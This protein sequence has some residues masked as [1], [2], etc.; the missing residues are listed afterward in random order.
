VWGETLGVEPELLN[1]DRIG[2]ALDAIA[3]HLDWIAGS[4][5]I[6]AIGEF[7]IEVTRMHWDRTSISMHGLYPDNQDGFPAVRFGHPK[8]RRPDL[9]TSRRGSR[10]APMEVCRCSTGPSTA[11]RGRSARSSA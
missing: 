5:G 6:T 9:N 2:R 11:V 7:G 1:D 4:V 3:P 10:S 8:D